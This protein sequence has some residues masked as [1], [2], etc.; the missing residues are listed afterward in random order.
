[1]GSFRKKGVEPLAISREPTLSI[2]WW[3]LGHRTNV[4]FLVRRSK[5][6]RYRHLEPVR[7]L[8]SSFAYGDVVGVDRALT[9]RHRGEVPPSLP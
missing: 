5:C 3:A 7:E 4:L 1:M 6:S 9:V 2:R 8:V